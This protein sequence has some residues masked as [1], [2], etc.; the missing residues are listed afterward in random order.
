MSF[1]P[2]PSLPILL[3]WGVPSRVSRDLL[4]TLPLLFAPSEEGV[5]L[6]RRYGALFARGIPRR[7]NRESL[8]DFLAAGAVVFPGGRTFFEGI[9]EVP[10]GH[11]LTVTG[12]RFEVT[13]RED[14]PEAREDL[15]EEGLALLREALTE[16]LG[17][18]GEEGGLCLSGGL[19]SGALAAAWATRGTPRCFL[20]DSGSSP[21]GILARAT[22][23][24]LGTEPEIVPSSGPATLE[25]LRHLLRVLEI[26][27][28]IPGAPLPQYRLLEALARRGVRRVLSGQGGDEVL[29]GYPWHFPLAMAKLGQRDPS[30]ARRLE[31]LHDQSPPF[32][33]LELRM[34]RRC[35]TRTASWVALNDGG[36]CALLGLSREEAA[37][38]EGIRSF[39]PDLPDWDALRRHGLTGR[40]LRYLLHYDHRLTSHF[41]LTGQA[42]FLAGP[43]VA[44]AARFRLETLYE[45]G[46]LKAPLRRIFP[47][48]PPSVRDQSAKTGFW[49]SGPA[50]PDLRPEVRRLLRTTPLGDLAARPEAVENLNQGT[51]WRFFGVG[52]LLET[53]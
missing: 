40:S 3:P 19:D 21:D 16:A 14:L 13:R 45:E 15:G 43:V 4:G 23:E 46:R 1:D 20:Y 52:T 39:S 42:P 2:E 37:N 18:P 36:A 27:S 9:F 34:V 28:H 38:R 22:A 50:L 49:H 32:P 25:E 11:D 17:D 10:P 5:F 26:P 44:L 12:D 31:A 35:F 30:A 6:G 47:E 51:L 48:L 7:W 29:C 53:P 8:T 24:A 41:G 33:P